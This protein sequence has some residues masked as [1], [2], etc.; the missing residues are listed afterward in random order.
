MLRV[1]FLEAI[2]CGYGQGY[3]WWHAA[4]SSH[5]VCYKMLHNYR[6]GTARIC[7]AAIVV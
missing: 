1:G 6:Y 7:A 4:S 5:T 2:L 3:V